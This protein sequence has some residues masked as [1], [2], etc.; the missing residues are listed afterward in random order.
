MEQ[1]FWYIIANPM[2]GNGWVGKHWPVVEAILQELGYSYTVKFTEHRDH[3]IRL[4]EDAVLKGHRHILGVG[5]DGTNHEIANGI[6]LQTRVPSADI[7]YALL[8]VGTGNDWA[9]CSVNFT[10]YE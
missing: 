7:T 2:A 6:L 3:A 1:P 5:G 9:R 8:P 10:V 4:V